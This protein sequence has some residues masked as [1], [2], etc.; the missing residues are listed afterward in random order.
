MG[1]RSL[2]T[3]LFAGAALLSGCSSSP[4]SEDALAYPATAISS[5]G[6]YAIEA[7]VDGGAPI[8]R[9]VHGVALRVEPLVGGVSAEGLAITI[10][11]WM[12]A[13]GHGSPYDGAVLEVGDGD[14]RAQEVSLFMAGRWEL[15]TTIGPGGERATLSFD[16][17]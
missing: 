6:T 16:V 8:V 7:T 11:P 9:G 3:L 12:P 1:V 14:Y 17:R 10:Q 2:A 15:R 13:M 5:L 4:S